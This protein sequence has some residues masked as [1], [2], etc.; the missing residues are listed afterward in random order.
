MKVVKSRLLVS[1][2]IGLVVTVVSGININQNIA[3]EIPNVRVVEQPLLGASYWG[4][5]L[6]WLRQIIV[7][8]A[9]KTV[10]WLNFIADVLV[11]TIIAYIVLTLLKLPAQSRERP[12]RRRNKRPARRARRTARRS[13]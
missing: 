2:L 3:G 9:I 8:G 10:M 1:I 7:P 6:P 5:I 4:Y 11:W 12:D 13:R